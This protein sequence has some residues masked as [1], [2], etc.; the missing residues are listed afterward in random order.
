MGDLAKILGVRTVHDGWSKFMVADVLLADGTEVTRQIEDHG[1]A[2]AVLPYDPVRR[3]V[4]L[5][6]LMRPAPLYAADVH[7]LI[8]APA[9]IIDA[10]ETPAVAARREAMEEVGVKLCELESVATVWMSPG[11]STET[12]AL[13]LAP[14]AAADRIAEG[15]GLESEH[16]GI[17]VLELPAAEAWR[18]LD[19]GKIADMKTLALIYALRLRHPG[20]FET[21]PA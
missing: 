10:G 8:E 7:E 11:I 5:V 17:T 21:V 12:I 4:L 18:M 14:Y 15:G 16:E 3:T 13:F 20:V 2:T 1:V 19:T 6:Q 9:G